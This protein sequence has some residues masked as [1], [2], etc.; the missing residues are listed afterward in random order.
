MT[1]DSPSANTPIARVLGAEPDSVLLL[2]LPGT[3]NCFQLD[4]VDHQA[5]LSLAAARPA[6]RHRD[7]VHARHEGAFV[8]SYV[9][10]IADVSFPGEGPR[11]REDHG[12]SSWGHRCRTGAPLLDSN[13]RQSSR[14]PTSLLVHAT[15]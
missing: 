11:V 3:G 12:A 10:P 2:G 1:V 6:G 7:S 8:D 4:D 13:E 9:H 15:R 5:R 14:T